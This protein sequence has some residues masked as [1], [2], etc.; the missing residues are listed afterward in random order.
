MVG[1]ADRRP[2]TLRDMALSLGLVAVV[3][4][5][6]VGMYGG[7]SFSPGQAT[8]GQTPT[9]DVTGGFQRAEPLV[10]F[11]VVIPPGLPADWHPN[12]FSFTDP[13]TGEGP[14]ATTGGPPAVRGGWL[15]PESR[16][17]M[18]VESSGSVPKVL[19][20]ELGGTGTRTATG[21]VQVGGAQ[22]PAAEW[23]VTTGRRGEAAWFRTVDG[24]TYLITGSAPAA[25][26]RAV[27]R[28]VAA[29]A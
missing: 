2:T 14:G 24:V 15:T 18:L 26:F 21:T 22:S 11:T 12:S 27:A 9:A 8:D 28:A 10:G 7:I 29:P 13:A 4:L 19:E 6:L 16:F 23:T 25:D 1:V 5:I 17:I 20:A 3:A